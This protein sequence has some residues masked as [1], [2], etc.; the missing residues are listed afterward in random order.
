[1]RT[2]CFCCCNAHSTK[3]Q[4]LH[5]RCV[6]GVEVALMKRR[7]TL[8]AFGDI[9]LQVTRYFHQ[10]LKLALLLVPGSILIRI[11]VAKY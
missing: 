3:L 8:I 7:M 10:A 6:G 9:A 5:T 4:T 11:Y 1:M 2:L